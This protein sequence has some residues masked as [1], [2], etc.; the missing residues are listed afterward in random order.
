MSSSLF[1]KILFA[2]GC[3]MPLSG[4]NT[5][6]DTALSK[7]FAPIANSLIGTKIEIEVNKSGGKNYQ[8]WYI[9]H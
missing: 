3:Q 5:G 7:I 4:I 8:S 6:S 1:S 9:S 2:T